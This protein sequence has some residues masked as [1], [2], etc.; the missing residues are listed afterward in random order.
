[1]DRNLIGSDYIFQYFDSQ[2]LLLQKCDSFYL[3]EVTSAI[4]DETYQVISEF[5]GSF[6]HGRSLLPFRRGWVLFG[7]TQMEK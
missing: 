7:A 1:M 6:V 3:G 2:D 5:L 4:I